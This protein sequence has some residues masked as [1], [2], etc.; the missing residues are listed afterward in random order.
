MIYFTGDTHGD[1]KAFRERMRRNPLSGNDTLIILG[2]FGFSWDVPTENSWLRESR[3]YRT[4]FVDGNH[5]NYTR[6][7]RMGTEEMYGDT[8]GVFGAN[9]Y[10]LLTGHMYTVEGRKLFVYGGA[11]SIDKD[12]RTDPERVAM[13]GKT[14]WKEEVPSYETLDY[15]LE[16][17]RENQWKFDFFLSHTTTPERKMRMF[18]CLSSGFFDPVESM[19]RAL[20]EEIESNGG[21]WKQSFFGHFHEDADD[22]RY[23]CLMNRVIGLD[24]VG[25]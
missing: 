1:I 2:D 7:R 5:E 20:E 24:A 4:L 23:H 6:M 12:W 11:S 21:E 14:W 16:T 10:R 13:W 15:A 9:T 17:L 3:P 8:V 19:I 25:G 22:G 18:P